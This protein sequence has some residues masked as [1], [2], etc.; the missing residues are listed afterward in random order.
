MILFFLSPKKIK[1]KKKSAKKFDFPMFWGPCHLIKVIKEEK[2]TRGWP[3][4]NPQG[5]IF[6]IY[7]IF[8]G[9]KKNKII[10]K[11]GKKG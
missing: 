5:F 6:F 3:E 2:D 4:A 7:F 10:R 9:L 1:N 8:F 11:K